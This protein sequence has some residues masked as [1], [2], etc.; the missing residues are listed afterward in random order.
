MRMIR[1]FRSLGI[2]RRF[3]A[4]LGLEWYKLSSQV[5]KCPE[6]GLKLKNREGLAFGLSL[7]IFLKQHALTDTLWQAIVVACPT[8]FP[9]CREAQGIPRLLAESL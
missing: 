5:L 6:N 4:V 1:D 9:L 7:S 8:D 2:F 3:K